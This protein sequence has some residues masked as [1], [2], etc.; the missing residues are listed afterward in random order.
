MM[1]SASEKS[2]VELSPQKV[3]ASTASGIEKAAL[4]VRRKGTDVLVI[5]LEGDWLMRSRLPSL[6]A[7]EPELNQ[8]VPPR[9]MEFDTVGLGEWDSGL[10]SFV[11]KCQEL[12]ERRQMRFA[13]ETLPPG[14]RK[15]VHLALAVPETKD[16]QQAS[17]RHSVLHRLGALALKQWAGGREVLAFLGENVVAS[18]KLL[19][20]KAQLRW[21]DVWLVVQQCG[22]EALGVV[23]L[24]NFLVGVILAFVGSV[25][26]IR[27]GASIYVADLV[28]IGTVREM[29]CIMTGVILCG[30]TGAAF[31]AQLGAMKVN[32]E[33][34]AFKT[35]GISPIEFLVLPR[36]MALLLMMPLLCVFADV[37]AI[38]GGFLVSISMLDV[39]ATEYIRRTIEAITLKNFFLGIFKGGFFGILVAVFGCL[40]GMQ[41]GTNAAA[42]GQATTSSVVTGITSIVAA[43]GIFAVLCNAL[44][45]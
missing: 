45:I 11:L 7:L 22:P 12:S 8:G 44:G 34:D 37:I 42:V 21:S 33:I 9:R 2:Y 20:G 19:R 16:A 23:A 40:R 25:Q 41:C 30:R 29:G 28:A 1:N 17:V 4:E 24:I 31:A 27:F 10:V 38:S 35:F 5:A 26:L 13:S 18:L 3:G 15:L 14:L 43:D 36:I 39:T 6:E 32:E